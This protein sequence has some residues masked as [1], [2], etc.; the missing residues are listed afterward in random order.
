MHVRVLHPSPGVG[1]DG[2]EYI[3]LRLQNTI[4]MLESSLES[5]QLTNHQMQE[6]TKG[7]Y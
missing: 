5:G 4:N 1:I 7:R 6:F 3:L 2:R